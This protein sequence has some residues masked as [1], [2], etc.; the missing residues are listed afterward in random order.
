MHPR[1]LI[2][3]AM[4]LLLGAVTG[5]TSDQPADAKAVDAIAAADTVV[6]AYYLHGHRRCATCEKLE[7]YTAEAVK[8]GFSEQIGDSSVVWRVLNFEEEP[9]EH[10][11]EHYEL[12]TQSVILSK[13]V[14][15]EEIVWKNLDKIWQ[16]VGDKEKYLEY[17]KA[18]VT[19]FVAPPS[20]E[21]D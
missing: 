3:I 8:T 12:I 9:N 10:L 7:A 5:Y 13:T 2:L 17:I 6:T 4:I 20:E 15:G 11:A 19:A 16:L 21:A 1:S 18:E 14:D